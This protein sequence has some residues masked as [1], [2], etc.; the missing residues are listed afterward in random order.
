ML[1]FIFIFFY[2]S[3]AFDGELKFFFYYFS[4]LLYPEETVSRELYFMSISLSKHLNVLVF[5]NVIFT[6][7]RDLL[8]KREKEEMERVIN[9]TN[10]Q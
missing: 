3:C 2:Y 5:Y 1:F 7:I 4:L 8:K 9:K 10:R 6:R